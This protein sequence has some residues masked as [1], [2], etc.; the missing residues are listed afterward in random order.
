MLQDQGRE[1]QEGLGQLWE[2]NQDMAQRGRECSFA[3]LWR[4]G[5]LGWGSHGEVMRM[6]LRVVES[7][8]LPDELLQFKTE[9]GRIS[10]V[11]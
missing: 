8:V 9:F 4:R 3:E 7:Q 1:V 5:G 2:G 6:L 11:Y 10:L